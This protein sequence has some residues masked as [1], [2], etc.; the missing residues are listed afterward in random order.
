MEQIWPY[1]LDFGAGECDP[2]EKCPTGS[3]PGLWEVPLNPV[4]KTGNTCE[5]HCDIEG[6]MAPYPGQQAADVVKGLTYNFEKNYKGDRAP[7]GVFLHT[8][9]LS[10]KSSTNDTDT[11][12]HAKGL[13]TFLE[14]L[15]KYEDVWVV[16]IPQVIEWMKTV[17]ADTGTGADP[18]TLF[19][20]SA[21]PLRPPAR[22]DVT[23]HT[24]CKGGLKKDWGYS[25]QCE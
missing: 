21:L 12:Q 9:W 25:C 8:S 11:T 17:D 20:P 13:R 10:D 2:S 3:Y 16:T 22:C 4:Y 6:L 14:G 1:T 7:F 5:E 19:A 15:S 24:S 23:N 18:A